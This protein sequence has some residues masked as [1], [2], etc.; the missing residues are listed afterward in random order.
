MAT[1][2]RRISEPAPLHE[3]R[4][5][6]Q[7][8]DARSAQSLLNEL[9]DAP[10]RFGPAFSDRPLALYGAGNL[11]RL[12]RDF[13][14]TVGRECA[15]VIDR[16]AGELAA[17]PG[18]GELPALRP[19][20]VPQGAR[21]RV[22]V[23]VSIAT[24]PYVLIERELSDLG[25]TQVLPFYDLAESFR[26]LHP[27]SNG[28][29]A[30]PMTEEDRQ[31]TTAVLQQWNDEV[32]RAHHLQ[33]LAWRKVRE[34]WAFE[35]APVVG[36]NRFFI[37][38]VIAVLHREEVFLDAGAYH[39]HVTREFIERTSGKFRRIIAVEPD[40][41]NRSG[42]KHALLGAAEGDALFHDGLGYASQLSETGRARVMVRPLDAFGLS[43]TFMKLHLEGGELAA[44]EGGRQTLLA[45]RPLI[46][47]TVYHNADGIWRTPLWLMQ[48]LPDYRFLFRL[49]SWCGTGA[50]LYAIPNE[51]S[52]A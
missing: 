43:P 28:W 11:G 23:A 36:C 4:R 39:G 9:A 15:M 8:P 2:S 52:G 7:M 17:D 42:L 12:A 22:C 50:V 34:E 5:F 44:L 47:A 33:F 29:F 20:E 26:H 25:F 14:K 27:L 49:H 48:T 16:N 51:R 41:W 21:H 38:E 31:N 6:D 24:A 30:P 18:W 32:S 46:A 10:C 13:L 1:A 3:A 37:P 40:P 35:Q 45:S 19:A